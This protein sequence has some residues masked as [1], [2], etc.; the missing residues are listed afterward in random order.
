MDGIDV[1][2]GETT[3]DHVTISGSPV[4]DVVIGGGA[5]GAA[6]LTERTAILG[7]TFSGG[8]RDIVSASGPIALRV[9]GNTLG[10]AQRGAAAGLH[11]RAADRGQ[12]ILDVHV[13]GNTIAGNAGPGIL[14][15]LDPSDGAPI[16]ADG[17]EITGNKILHN[18]TKAPRPTR[19]GVVVV[20]G[21]DDGKGQLVFANN[22]V[23][24]NRG[25]GL[26]G[27]HFRL[28][29]SANGNDLHQNSGGA[30]RGLTAG[31]TTPQTSTGS[32]TPPLARLT[33]ADGRD[34]TAWLQARLDVRGGTIF[35][36]TLPGGECYATH[37]LWVSHDD[38]TITSD[39]A[40]IVSLGPGAVRLHSNDGDPIPSE[41]VFYVS[42]SGPKKPAPV[43][44]TI[45]NLRI[46]VPPGGQPMYGVAVNAHEVTLSNLDISGSPKDDVIIGARNNANGYA[47]HIALLDSVLSGAMRNGV[48]ASSVIDL[49]IQGNTIEGV[50]NLP[51]G[52]PAAGI[53]IEPDDRSQPVLG[54][55]ILDNTI[56][57]NAG[58]G[59][60]FPL[61]TNYGPTLI[62][63]GLEISGNT[64][65]GNC[66]QRTPPIR[67]GIAVLGGQDGGQGTLELT[68][69]V[70][71]DNGGPGILTRLLKLI[72]HASGNQVSNNHG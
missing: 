52:Q 46:I 11:L 53:D 51:P 16:L 69:N 21:Q 27:R 7:C 28:A 45:S 8:E 1:Y 13:I 50:R 10:G 35:L 63:T 39:G 41:A 29:L 71:R 67:A 44:V 65:V 25:P 42:P 20:G 54:V 68:N 40:C 24:D 62:A 49:R 70:V 72:V 64:I 18:A 59:I 66:N 9:E 17:I 31:P 48:S 58:S 32:W 14:A 26:L 38:T 33:G 4:R 43:N 57:D 55:R 56:R 22:V 6:G 37:G 15:D 3:L 12:P 36:P 34:D 5:T 2:G 19:G 60:L 61:D 30:T 47:G 23:R